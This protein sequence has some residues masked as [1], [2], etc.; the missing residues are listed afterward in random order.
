M[1]VFTE[2]IV[3]FGAAIIASVVSAKF[4]DV[5]DKKEV[6]DVLKNLSKQGSIASDISKARI[7]AVQAIL[8]AAIPGSK[9][10]KRFVIYLNGSLIYSISKIAEQA[11]KS[12]PEEKKSKTVV[13]LML[14]EKLKKASKAQFFLI[15]AFVINSLMSASGLLSVAF[16]SKGSSLVLIIVA[17][18]FLAIH[19]DHMLLE[20]RIKHGLYGNN[21]FEAREIIEFIISHARKDDFND[22]GGLKKVIPTPVLDLNL[23]K[24]NS[25]D[26]G[27]VSV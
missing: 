1:S 8:D 17:I 4:K 11:L 5:L 25:T 27:G 16:E 10:Y 2:A 19:I 23:N 13:G 6:G 26:R 3:V 18:A 12:S 7:I 14:G 15:A 9:I 21:E 24:E 20:Y 22:S